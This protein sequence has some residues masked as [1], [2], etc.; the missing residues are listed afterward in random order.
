[1]PGWKNSRR[2]MTLPPN[3]AAIRT[4][5]LQRDGHQCTW[6]EHGERCTEPATDVDHITPGQNH[7]PQNLRSLCGPHHRSKS[8]GEG[9]RAS[10]KKRA[11]RQR[12][13]EQ[14]PGTITQRTRGNRK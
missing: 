14:H 8:S 6:T 3:W 4:R 9:G 11:K 2:R 1:M 7:T 5:V 10:A 13:P 12:P